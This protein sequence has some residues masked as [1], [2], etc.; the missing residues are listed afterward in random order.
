MGRVTRVALITGGSSGL[1]LA[2]AESLGRQNYAV[3]L[4]ARG[5]ARLD[6]AA[7]YL[8][9]VLGDRAVIEGKCAP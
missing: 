2:L 4:V 3:I 6:S 5:Q 7:A 8:G 1:G 9:G